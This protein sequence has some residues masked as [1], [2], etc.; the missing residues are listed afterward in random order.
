M[1]IP[2]YQTIMRPL[3]AM[4]E[5]GAQRRLSELYTELC[6]QF[7]LTENEREQRVNSGR[8]TV[9]R[10]RVGW[11]RTYLHKAGL[12]TIPVR[13]YCQITERGR[14][15]LLDNPERLDNRYLKQFPEF[16]AF[17]TPKTKKTDTAQAQPGAGISGHDSQE[18]G[19]EDIATP[20]EALQAAYTALQQTLAS[21]LLDTI[22]QGPPAFFEQLV[23]DVMLAMGYGGSREEAGRATQL[24]ADGGIDGI[25]SEDRLGLDNIY[26]QAKRWEGTVGR[27]DIQKFAGALQGMKAKKGV[28]ITTSDYSTEA[29]AFASNLDSSM[30]LIN[31]DQLAELMIEF[32]V[33]V[34]TKETYIVKAIDTDYF[35]DD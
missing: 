7:E 23:V 16:I 6:D 9:M 30:V 19:I 5:D 1:P 26:L 12:L 35:L 13:S 2:D 14:K 32:G 18:A 29:K 27:P 31:G 20:E 24:S 8:Q 28:F 11:A 21:D 22:K 4:L 3:L 17:Q 34:T 10:N 25:I 15:A 33:G